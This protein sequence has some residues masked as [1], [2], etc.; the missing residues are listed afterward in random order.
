MKSSIISD[1]KIPVMFSSNQ[2]CVKSK[3]DTLR[4]LTTFAQ[5]KKC[6]KHPWRSDTLSCR[7]QPKSNTPSWMFFT[8]FKLHKWYQIIQ[9]I[10]KV[11][12]QNA[13]K[14]TRKTDLRNGKN[15]VVSC[16]PYHKLSAFAEKI[17]QIQRRV[18]FESNSL[19]VCAVVIET[20]FWRK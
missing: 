8:F 14:N 6:E 3:R 5:F 4:D 16:F 7:L 9:S 18:N 15:L 10:S 12:H 19:M 2:Q 20:Y 11:F 13:E 17:N 1:T